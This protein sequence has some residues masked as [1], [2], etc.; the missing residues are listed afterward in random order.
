MKIYGVNI[1][2]KRSPRG[3]LDVRFVLRRTGN[4]EALHEF[5]ALLSEKGESVRHWYPNRISWL[6]TKTLLNRLRPFDCKIPKK[7]LLG[8]LQ[9]LAE[10][11][12]PRCVVHPT[13][14][15]WPEAPLWKEPLKGRPQRVWATA[16]AVTR[17]DTQVLAE[18]YS[19]DGERGNEGLW[20][21]W[22]LNTGSVRRVTDIVMYCGDAVSERVDTAPIDSLFDCASLEETW[23]TNLVLNTVKGPIQL[24]VHNQI[25]KIDLREWRRT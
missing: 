15:F 16:P 6:G 14:E 4:F 17:M 23:E 25:P 2:S 8:F 10:N 19:D 24:P 22:R 7:Y 9:F 5:L 21:A 11:P 13:K 20:R 18:F 12:R 1:G 3:S